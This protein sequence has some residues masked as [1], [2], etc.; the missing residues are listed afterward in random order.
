MTLKVCAEP[1][2]PA[3]VPKGRC[4]EHRRAQERARGSRQ[5]RGYDT[6]HDR[7]RAQWAPKVATGRVRCH[8]PRCL[9]PDDPLIHPDEPWDLGHTEDRRSYHG[10]EH[11]ACNR[12]AGGHAAHQ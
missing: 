2:C 8:S 1:G 4:A 5:Q 6:T 7:L 11:A 10:P 12:S 3:L 9:R